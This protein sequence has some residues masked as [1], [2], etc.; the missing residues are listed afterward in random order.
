MLFP[1]QGRVLLSQ[2][3]ARGKAAAEYLLKRPLIRPQV[4]HGQLV[5]RAIQ[6]PA[7]DIRHD[8]DI[9]SA[10]QAALDLETAGACGQQLRQ[11]LQGVQVAHGQQPAG[12][13]LVAVL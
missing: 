2:G 10:F 7:V 4:A 13:V 12:M 3:V 6:R 8:V 5:C 1:D 11:G 9:L